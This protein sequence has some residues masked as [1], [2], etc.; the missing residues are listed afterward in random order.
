M[1]ILLLLILWSLIEIA[2]FVTLG[3]WIGLG[4]TLLWV[5]GTGVLGVALIRM[6]GVQAGINLRRDLT[7]VSDPGS[8]VAKAA[9]LVLAA[10]LLILPG[11]FS[12]FVGLALLVPAVRQVVIARIVSRLGAARAGPP[13]GP[14]Y[15]DIVEAE[16]IEVMPSRDGAEPS[17][18]TK[19]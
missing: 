4:F 19:V 10:I 15:A 12:D 2:L 18:W 14:G 17:G 5:V 9:L 8:Q 13:R 7:T 1:R 6:V 11:F 16:V 3:G